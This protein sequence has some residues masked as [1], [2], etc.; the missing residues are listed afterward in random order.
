MFYVLKKVLV[1]AALSLSLL[2]T[3]FAKTIGIVVFDGVLTSDVVSPLEVFGIADKK[4]WFSDYDVVTI[5]VENVKKIKTEEGLTIEVDSW[6]GE[7][8]NLDVVLLPSRYDMSPLL[9]NEK[10]INFIKKVDQTSVL[11][12][13]NC[14][15]ASLLAKSGVLNGRKAT[16][17]AGG[18][19]DLRKEF[20][21][22]DVVD[23]KNVVIDGKYITSNGSVVGYDSAL[24]ALIHL[25]STSNAKEV[26]DTLQM[27]RITSWER[28]VTLS[29]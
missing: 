11:T 19:S 3:A 26:F 23:D 28:I 15:G 4:A 2:N 14:S 8:M 29:E 20:P 21:A 13:S 9:S 27:G 25:S 10:L 22:V 5:A 24:V 1:I 17:W 12:M 16:T 6:I 18:E 7:E